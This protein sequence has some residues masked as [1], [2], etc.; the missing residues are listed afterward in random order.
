MRASWIA[1]V[2]VSSVVAVTGCSSAEEGDD[3]TGDEMG[4]SQD[5]VREVI[6]GP[7]AKST[8]AEVW[9]ATNAWADRNTAEAKKAGLAWS[10]N[11][12]LSWEEK[13][14][15][16]IGSFEKIDGRRYGK[17]IRITTPYGKV[18]D[19]PVLECADV[20]IWLRMTFSA[21]YHL[22]FYMTGW[23]NG[24]TIYFGHFGVV[25]RD[26]NPVSGFPR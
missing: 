14:R 8:D 25:D 6:P 16:W 21:W 2:L 3:S 22:P 13:Y 19:G 18:L 15:K 11:S 17:T 20:G 10:A 24:Q 4:Q 9:A 12:G 5:E 7:A 23:R 26:G 1:A